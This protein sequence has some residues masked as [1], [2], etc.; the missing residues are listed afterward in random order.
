MIALF[1]KDI[2][3]IRFFSRVGIFFFKTIF[4]ILLT[5]RVIKEVEGIRLIVF[6]SDLTCIC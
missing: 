2:K 6:D 4:K 1:D 3:E 5:E